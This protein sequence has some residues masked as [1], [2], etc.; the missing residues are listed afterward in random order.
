M[1]IAVIGVGGR[2]EASWSQVSA[3]NIVAMCYVDAKG[4]A[5]GFEANPNAKKYKDFRVMFDEMAQEIDAVIIATPDHAHFPASMAAMQLG[6]HVFVEKP[7][8]H[9]I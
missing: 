9:N 6:K 3:E 7:L 4:A 1:N 5:Q 8:A 2:G